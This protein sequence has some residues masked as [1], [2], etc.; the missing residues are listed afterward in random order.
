MMNVKLQS[1]KLKRE[2]PAL[3]IRLIPGVG[4]LLPHKQVPY[5]LGAVIST[6]LKQE[7]KGA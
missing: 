5:L 1:W 4:K 6:F 2:M 7:L 3:E